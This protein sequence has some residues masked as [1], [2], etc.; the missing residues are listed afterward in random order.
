MLTI[1]SVYHDYGVDRDWG[2]PQGRLLYQIVLLV[3]HGRVVY[4]VED[5]RLV[6][7]KGDVLFM[8]AGT[9]RSAESCPDEPHQMYSAHFSC[10]GEWTGVLDG[11]QNGPHRLLHTNQFEYARHRFHHLMQVWEGR[12][13]H[14]ALQSQG[15]LMD[16]LAALARECGERQGPTGKTKLAARVQ[17][18]LHRHYRSDI[19]LDE[20][21]AHVERSP[22]YISSVF[23]EVI[24]ES[25]IAHM[26]R[27]RIAAAQDYL[28]NTSLN[29]AEIAELLGYC[30]QSYFGYMYKKLTGVSPSA[31]VHVQKVR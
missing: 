26:H 30:D 23:K 12:R 2:I 4:H 28:L 3:T 9:R 31:Y 11:I 24:G 16:L 15:V 19:K 8:R 5:E 1:H 22:N 14:Y 13:Q 25:P 20:L 10:D 27:L 6:L 7:R 17:H 29:V 18:Y 21:A